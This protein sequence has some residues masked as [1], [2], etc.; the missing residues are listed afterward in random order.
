MTE[1][2]LNSVRSRWTLADEARLLELQERKARV[3]AQNRGPVETLVLA[4]PNTDVTPLTN[5]LIVHA[6]PMRA[7]LA[8]F[9]EE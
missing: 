8:P 7:A 6:G 5:W 4:I 3:E 2:Q 1:N 9:D